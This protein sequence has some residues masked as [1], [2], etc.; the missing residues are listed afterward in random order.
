M[1]SKT[2]RRD[3]RGK[4]RRKFLDSLE[5][6]VMK[7]YQLQ[8]SSRTSQWLVD[9]Q[10][11][12]TYRIS[13]YTVLRKVW[14][15]FQRELVPCVIGNLISCF[16][17]FYFLFGKNTFEAHLLLLQK[18]NTVTKQ[19]DRRQVLCLWS[20]NYCRERGPANLHWLYSGWCWKWEKKRDVFQSNNYVI[21][22]TFFVSILIS[23]ICLSGLSSKNIPKTF[24]LMT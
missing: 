3:A 24:C 21:I 8:Q 10:T 23:W 12:W 17:F 2:Q 15:I 7:R 11:Y 6:P 19:I 18:I 22:F 20:T 5:I 1:A 16:C 4:R 13:T 9:S 14:C